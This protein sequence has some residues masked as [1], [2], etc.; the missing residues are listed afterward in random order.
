M[1]DAANVIFTEYK[2][3]LSFS[4]QPGAGDIF[5]K[6]FVD[7]R[8]RTDRV[9]QIDLPDCPVRPHEY[10]H[11]PDDP[12]L[13]TFDRSDRVFVAL[14]IAH[15]DHPEILNAVDSDYWHHRIALLRAGVTVN[16]VCGHAHFR[17]RI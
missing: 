16:N 3:H 10:Q 9:V 12:D 17:P 15:A 7:N 1:V 13:T 8:Y 6:W 14:A 2:R 4:G 11:F 5:F